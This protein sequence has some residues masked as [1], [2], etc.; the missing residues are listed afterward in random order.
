MYL[1]CTE[2]E[3]PRNVMPLCSNNDAINGVYT[4]MLH[5]FTDID[6]N[7][8]SSHARFVQVF[9]KPSRRRHPCCPCKTIVSVLMAS[10]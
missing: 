1:T 8:A 2:I 7:A 4:I 5:Y 10:M 9:A 6:T 3:I